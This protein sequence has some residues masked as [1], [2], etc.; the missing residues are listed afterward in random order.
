MGIPSGYTSAQ[1]VQAV[2]S[3]NVSAFT[4]YT[5]TFTN[6]TVCNGTVDFKFIQIGKFVHVQGGILFGSTTSISANV[7][8]TL[9]VTAASV[10]NFPNIGVAQFHDASTSNRYFGAVVLN[11]TTAAGPRLS[12]VSTYVLNVG[13]NA[14]IPFTWTT[15]DH[16]LMTFIYE[17]A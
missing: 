3:N 1:V 4:A 10:L 13:T 11:S 8:I 16:I 5:P 14:T 9:P 2:P 17:A 7:E 12:G 6:L 15:G